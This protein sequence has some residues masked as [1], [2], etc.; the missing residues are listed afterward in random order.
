M[1][2]AETQRLGSSLAVRVGK[3]RLFLSF[4][5]LQDFQWKY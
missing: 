5:E 2:S 4:L 1:S 3:I